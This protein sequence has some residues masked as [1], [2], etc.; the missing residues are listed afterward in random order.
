MKH[1]INISRRD[2]CKAGALFGGGLV[3]GF[4]VDETHAAPGQY[5][6]APTVFAPNAFIRIGSDDTV[7]I[8]VNKSEMGQGVYTSL[9]MLIAEELEV[10]WRKIRIEAAPV[11][12]AYN[13][14]QWG[15]QGTGGSTS[16]RSCWDQFRQAGAAARLMLEKA[17]AVAWN[18]APDTCRAEN[19]FVTDTANNKRLSFGELAAGAARLEAPRDPPLKKSHEFKVLGKS[20]KRLD[21]PDKTNGRAIFGIDIMLPGLLTAVVAR[22]PVF[23]G[24]VKSFDEAAAKKIAGVKAVVR[25]ERGIA[26]VADHFWAASRGRQ[27]L[28]VSWDEGPLAGLDSVEQKKQYGQLAEQPGLIAAQRGDVASALAGA[29]KKVEAVYDV[30]Y[31]AHA[32]MEPLNCV[33]DVRPD[34]CEIWVGTQLQT[35]DRDAA[36]GLT[37]LPKEKVQLHTTYLGG[38]FGR[39]AVGDSHFVKEAVQISQAVKAPVKVIWTRE[40]DIQGGYYRPAAYNKL[41]A[42]LDDKGAPLALRHTVVSQSIA[43][44]TPFEG[45]M[46]KDGIDNTAVEGVADSPYEIPHLL[47]D[48]HMA[49]A[50]VPVLWWRSVGHSY[51][52]FVKEGFMDELAVTAG[53]DPYDYRRKLLTA[54]PRLLG[55]LDLAAEKAGWGKAA[56][57]GISQG[58]AVHESFGSFIAQVAEVTVAK[59]GR[60]RVHRVVCAIDCGQVVNPD[61]IE[62]QM[63]S[64]VAFGLTA[65]LYGRITFKNGRVEQSNFHDYPLLRLPEMPRVEVHIMKSTAPPG[66]VG[67]PGV[68]PVAP[69]VANAVHAATGLRL[70]TLPM[71]PAALQAAGLKG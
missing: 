59:S 54:H 49:P 53:Q 8:I 51:T 42:G 17:A 26:V 11:D 38:G 48:Y 34:S 62:A 31:L 25:I 22:P 13:H 27:A 47:V 55:V 66:G 46:I 23:G 28:Q 3:L 35:Y 10:D 67:E 52:A 33:A 61:T 12:A 36:A 18:V 15:V 1:I 41:I 57:K 19:G 68:P 5:T 30:P 4:H 16:I 70:R 6:E 14:T 63:E 44:G 32:P 24:A 7:T 29:A 45:G 20:R 64:A 39:R 58:I 21:T 60:I 56:S 71:D 40:D 43:K 37:G 2:F 9:P 65:A 69:A 50:G